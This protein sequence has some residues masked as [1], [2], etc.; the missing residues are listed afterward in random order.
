MA[1]D[2]EKALEQIQA[3]DGEEVRAAA[4]VW[5]AGKKTLV[6]YDR[7]KI[8]AATKK[9]AV[10]RTAKGIEAPVVKKMEIK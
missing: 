4:R 9:L 3:K 6:E 2:Y 5:K 7:L 8:T 1:I 10:Y